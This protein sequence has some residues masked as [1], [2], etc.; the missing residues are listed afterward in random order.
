MDLHDTSATL[1]LINPLRNPCGGSERRTIDT[2]RLLRAHCDVQV[3]AARDAAPSLVREAGALA[4]NPALLRFPRR[5]T[6]VFVGTYFSVGRWIGLTTPTRVMVIF[7]TDQPLW[8]RDNLARIAASGCT[9]E[10][11]YTSHGLRERHRGVGP[12]LESPIDLDH[13]AFND[14]ASASPRPFTVGRHSRDDLSKHHAEDPELYRRLAAAGIRVRLMGATCLAH[15]L[16]GTPGIE[17]LPEGTLP[18]REF[19][20]GLDAFIYRTSQNWYEAFGRVVFESMAAGVPVVC[21]PAGGYAHYLEPGDNALVADTTD[22]LCAAVI[23]LRDDRALASRLARRA[24]CQAEVVQR[25]ATRELLRL[26]L[27]PSPRESGAPRKGKAGA[28]LDEA[29]LQPFGP[30]HSS[31]NGD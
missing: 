12:V 13:F 24:R 5:G 1:H 22:Q 2:A 4:I 21:A 25:N 8:L 11:I 9:A 16:D 10:V 29:S 31:L 30:T 28:R 14:P 17:I 23:A 27:A 3:W 7:N 26:L 15:E 20:R 6:L 19:L 18:A